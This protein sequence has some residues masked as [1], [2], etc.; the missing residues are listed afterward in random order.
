MLAT[1]PPVLDTKLMETTVSRSTSF[2]P[3]PGPTNECGSECIGGSHHGGF[4]LMRYWIP[5][6]ALT[7]IAMLSTPLSAH[8]G[9]IPVQVSVT[10]EGGNFQYTYA[11]VLPTGS[12]L[13][14][15]DYFTIYSFDGMVPGTAMASGSITST[16]WTFS[17][18]NVGPTPPGVIASNNPS[19][20]NISWTYS[21]APV[22]GSETGI[23]NFSAV[24]IYPYTTQS[25]FAAITG[26]VSGVADAN[27]TPTNVPVPTAPPPGVPEP[28]T[29]ALAAF[30]LPFFGLARLLRRRNAAK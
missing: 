12:V 4:N 10:P 21:G 24:S 5:A 30:G 19:I 22:Q 27:I 18:S 8:A 2:E 26:T 20:P 13:E 28:T 9:L 23:G 11:I 15:G 7:F 29:L 25:W 1:V 6:A 16:N 17:T 3:R 14:S